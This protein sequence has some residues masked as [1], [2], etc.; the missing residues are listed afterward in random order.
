MLQTQI[1]VCFKVRIDSEP[2]GTIPFIVQLKEA[3]THK[4]M[5]SQRNSYKLPI[6]QEQ[7]ACGSGQ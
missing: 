3:T 6:S 4:E 2:H 5:S 1:F 7:E